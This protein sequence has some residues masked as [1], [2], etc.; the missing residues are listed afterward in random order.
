MDCG[1]AS[2]CFAT[3]EPSVIYYMTLAAGAWAK[4]KPKPKPGP[5]PGPSVI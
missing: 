3:S 2:V 1:F 4:P 5:G